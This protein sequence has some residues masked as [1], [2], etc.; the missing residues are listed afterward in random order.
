MHFFPKNPCTNTIENN[1]KFQSPLRTAFA[2]RQLLGQTGQVYPLGRILSCLCHK[3]IMF[4]ILDTVGMASFS[5][6]KPSLSL[7][8]VFSQFLCYCRR[9]DRYP[10]RG[11]KS[12]TEYLPSAV[13]IWNFSKSF[14]KPQNRNRPIFVL[15]RA[16]TRGLQID[17]KYLGNSFT[18]RWLER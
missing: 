17:W 6:C 14:S 2:K 12:S 3:Y 7:R 16:S 11:G 1:L 8:G 9:W 15:W 10:G 4:L 18:G 5:S 13:K